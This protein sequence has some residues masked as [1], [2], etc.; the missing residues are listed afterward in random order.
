[1]SDINKIAV[2]ITGDESGLK[3]ATKEAQK[4]IKGVSQSALSM[5]S[6]IKGSA[7]GNVL[8]AVIAKGISAISQP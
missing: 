1:M 4:D 7:I 8:G 3:K 5:G 2:K 6:L